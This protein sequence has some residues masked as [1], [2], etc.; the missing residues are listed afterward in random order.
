MTRNLGGSPT[1]SVQSAGNGLS[2]RKTDQHV[3]QP[4]VARRPSRQVRQPK[5][6]IR[7]AQPPILSHS[8]GLPIAS[9]R[10]CCARTCCLRGTH[11]RHLGPCEPPVCRSSSI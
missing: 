11:S 1:I 2:L 8:P 10:R 5:P 3:P 6:A 7:E 4:D 9:L